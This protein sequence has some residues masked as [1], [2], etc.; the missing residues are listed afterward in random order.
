MKRF[1][2][3]HIAQLL[4]A[5]SLVAVP[6][7]GFAAGSDTTYR[8]FIHAYCPE[9]EG[10]EFCGHEDEE[11]YR[12]FVLDS[13]QELNLMWQITGISFQPVVLPIVNDSHFSQIQACEQGTLPGGQTQTARRL[14]WSMNVAQNFASQD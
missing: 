4:I 13:V 7:S 11:V 14:E 1:R 9:T 6:T 2:W 5:G 8:L 12:Q 10:D 3:I